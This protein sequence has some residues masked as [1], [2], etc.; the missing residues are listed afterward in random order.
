MH[1]EC[2]ERFPR[3]WLQRKLLVSDP[4]M[5]HDTCVTHVPWCKSG[6]LTRGRGKT[7]PA[8][9]AHAQPAIFTYLA[10]VPW[11]YTT[12]HGCR[13]CICNRTNLLIAK[14]INST[15]CLFYLKM[16]RYIILHKHI[17]CDHVL[18][19]ANMISFISSFVSQIFGSFLSI[20]ASGRQWLWYHWFR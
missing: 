20:D 1:R 8:F 9:P 5:H 10:R 2:R 12:W 3:H 6:S 16:Y 4:G 13:T 15:S 17:L 19:L 11:I 7:F 18:P 14:C